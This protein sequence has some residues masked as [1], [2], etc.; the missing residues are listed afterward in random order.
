MNRQELNNW[1]CGLASEVKR[2]KPQYPRNAVRGC[3]IPFFGNVLEARVLTVG[4][5]PSSTEFNGDRQ[6]QEPLSQP[7]WQ[8]RLLNYFKWPEVPAHAWFETWSI[9]LELLGVSYK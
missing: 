7:E 2:T 3:P 6:W 9:C 8:E 5:N 1:L 4:V